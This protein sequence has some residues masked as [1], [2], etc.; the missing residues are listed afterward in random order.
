MLSRSGA[1]DLGVNGYRVEGIKV[2]IRL[3]HAKC[4]GTHAHEVEGGFGPHGSRGGHAG[5]RCY[6]H[7]ALEMLGNAVVNEARLAES[8]AREL[9][10]LAHM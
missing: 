6:F 10:Q 8:L 3:V 9:P 2:D 7:M 5:P 1:D 4:N